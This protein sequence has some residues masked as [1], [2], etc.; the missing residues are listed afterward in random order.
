MP[1]PSVRSIV[2]PARLG[3]QGRVGLIQ[4]HEAV[5][6]AGVERLLE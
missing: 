2:V 6:V 3:D 1:S 4:L 5:E